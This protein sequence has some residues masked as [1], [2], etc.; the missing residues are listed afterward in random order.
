MV[1]VYWLHQKLQKCLIFRLKWPKRGRNT[2]TFIICESTES[3][4]ITYEGLIPGRT[5]VAYCAQKYTLSQPLL[6]KT[7]RIRNTFAS[8]IFSKS[9]VIT[10]SFSSAGMA[11]CFILSSNTPSPSLHT[12]SQITG[13][14][15]GVVSIVVSA[16]NEYN[17]VFNDLEPGTLYVAYCIQ[18]TLMS[19]PVRFKTSSTRLLVLTAD[20]HPFKVGDDILFHGFRDFHNQQMK[21]TDI[22]KLIKSFLKTF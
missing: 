21:V 15:N 8:S 2:P 14:G 16:L 20:A 5:Y 17:F 7:K 9:V 22:P 18:G 4:S 19:L 1:A 13:E 11:R 10:A 12:I 6:V 3:L